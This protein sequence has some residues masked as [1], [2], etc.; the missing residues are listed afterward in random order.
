MPRRRIARLMPRY[1]IARWRALMLFTLRDMPM[2][3]M[4]P[5]RVFACHAIMFRRAMPHMILR[6]PLLHTAFIFRFIAVMAPLFFRL[7]DSVPIFAPLR[8]RYVIDTPF[9]M[10][11]PVVAGRPPRRFDAAFSPPRSRFFFAVS[12]QRFSAAYAMP[13]LDDARR[14]CHVALS[15]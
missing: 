6:L 15:L 1:D 14:R 13:L 9:F 4:R 3:P 12:R 7:R 8:C 2:S 5:C 11:P 10:P